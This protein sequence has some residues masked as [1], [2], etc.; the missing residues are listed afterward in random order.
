[1]TSEKNTSAYKFK[2]NLLKVS[3]NQNFDDA[4]QEW[5]FIDCADLEFGEVQCI[6]QHSIA[7]VNYL[8][9]IKTRYTIAVGKDCFKK[10][11]MK[12]QP[13][14][15]TAL[16][17]LFKRC[18]GVNKGEYKSISDIEEYCR[19]VQAYVV[20]AFEAE[21]HNHKDDAEYT[22]KLYL[23]IHGLMRDYNITYLEGLL[24]SMREH[25][26]SDYSTR[27]AKFRY[28]SCPSQ[29]WLDF[30][31]WTAY[32]AFA[33]LTPAF[34]LFKRKI[35]MFEAVKKWWLLSG[36]MST[37]DRERHRL[38]LQERRNEKSKSEG[39]KRVEER[40][41]MFEAEKYKEWLNRRR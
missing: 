14:G 40:Q 41:R 37:Q 6:C 39:I 28:S 34:E 32:E 33:F 27:V 8:Y 19:L 12:K 5:K 10:F 20:E 38:I 26:K 16:C 36:G 23:E 9:N 21:Y 13:L 31:H 15:N 4:V 7:K 24:G 18:W 22:A 29:M 11:H 1:M 30:N 17:E 35:R 3:E 25:I 2:H